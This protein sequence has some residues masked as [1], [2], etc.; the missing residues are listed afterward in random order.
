MTVNDLDDSGQRTKFENG[1]QRERAEGKGRFDLIPP[2]A[3]KRM[4][5]VLEAG[6]KKYSA[7]NWEKGLPLST[8][9]DSGLRHL[10]KLMA[11]ESDEDHATLAMTNLAMFIALRDRI[12]A[13]TLSDEFDD[14]SDDDDKCGCDPN[15]YVPRHAKR[16][17][18]EGR[19]FWA[20]LGEAKDFEGWQEIGATTEGDWSSKELVFD[21][22]PKSVSFNVDGLSAD[23]LRAAFNGGVRVSE[24]I[25]S[26]NKCCTTSFYTMGAHHS[27]HCNIDKVHK[28]YGEAVSVNVPVGKSQSGQCVNGSCELCKRIY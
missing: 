14:L 24:G 11:G 19:L 3:I 9:I 16:E 6:A 26:N 25:R 27:P 12:E 2:E 1:G 15:E 22:F 20:P 8:F 23:N 21:E 28:I 17:P 18:N 10:N 4:A 13:G 7:R 5:L